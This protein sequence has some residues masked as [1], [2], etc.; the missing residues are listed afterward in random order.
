MFWYFQTCT[1]PDGRIAEMSPLALSN[2]TFLILF[3]AALRDIRLIRR[4]TSYTPNLP[5]PRSATNR[6]PSDDKSAARPSPKG[7]AVIPST[8]SAGAAGSGAVAAA[9]N[10]PRP[11]PPAGASTCAAGALAAG[12]VA[13]ATGGAAAAA[14]GSLGGA[15]GDS[16]G[17]AAS[18]TPPPGG[19][20]GALKS[21]PPPPPQP[22]MAAMT[23]NATNAEIEVPVFITRSVR[24]QMY[25]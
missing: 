14:F 23:S 16:L 20:I 21:S 6:R 19:L 22:M 17:W 9:P 4:L 13:G 2:E 10:N 3:S 5:S 7:E 1:L 24:S 25:Q 18:V 8:S 11:P 12:G 15:A